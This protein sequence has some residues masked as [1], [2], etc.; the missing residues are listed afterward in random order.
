MLRDPEFGP[1]RLRAFGTYAI[2]VT[3]PASFLPEIV[4]TDG[5]FT[6]GRDHLPDPQHHRAGIQRA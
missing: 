1:M 6:A 2:R 5:E 4:G 3:D